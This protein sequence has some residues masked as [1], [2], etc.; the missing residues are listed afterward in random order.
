M[1]KIIGLFVVLATIVSCSSTSKD[2]KFSCKSGVY[3]K[4]SESD[5]N[6]KSFRLK[7]TAYSN[8]YVTLNFKNGKAYGNSV[9]NNYSG[10]YNIIDGNRIIIDNIS[11]TLLAGTSDDLR[12]EN[13]FINLL[14]SATKISY[15]T[16][17]LVLT[18]LNNK[19]LVFVEVE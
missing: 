12:R 19:E 13:E 4:V 3:Y 6:G 18:T 14:G 5:L 17:K 16:G 1:K 15:C 9:V 7:N 8:D 2:Q 10:K 11:L